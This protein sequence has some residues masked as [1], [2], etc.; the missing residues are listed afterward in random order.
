[1]KKKVGS[2]RFCIDFRRVNAVTVFDSE[3]MGDI[4]DTL[5]QLAKKENYFTAIDLS[6]DNVFPDV[7]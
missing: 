2:N 7:V 1:V 3:P 4:K 6:K 5:A